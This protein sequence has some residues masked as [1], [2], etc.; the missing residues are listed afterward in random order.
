M[1]YGLKNDGVRLTDGQLSNQALQAV[2]E[3]KEKISSSIIKV[4]EE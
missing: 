2:Q 4:P 3:A 1:S